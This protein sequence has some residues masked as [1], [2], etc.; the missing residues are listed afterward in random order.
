MLTTCLTE[1]AGTKAADPVRVPAATGAAVRTRALTPVRSLAVQ[2]HAYMDPCI[3]P[4]KQCAFADCDCILGSC[5]GQPPSINL[6]RPLSLHGAA[7]SLV[8]PPC[9]VAD[10]VAADSRAE[11]IPGRMCC[12]SW[13]CPCIAQEAQGHL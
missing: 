1:Q 3:D 2:S 6:L 7:I 4:I 13:E 11:A 10:S 12:H 9:L 5:S 8:H